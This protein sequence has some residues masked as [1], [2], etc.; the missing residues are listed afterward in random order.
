ME[1]PYATA[2]LMATQF[3]AK[4]F[5]NGLGL[6]RKHDLPIPVFSDSNLVLVICG[7]GKTNAAMGTTYCCITFKPTRILN[8]GAAGAVDQTSKLGDV[9]QIEKIF[10]PDRPS[11]NTRG[12][13][14]HTPETI[15]GFKTTTLATQDRPILDPEDR[16]NI[17]R[18]AHLVDMEA[19][20]VVQV[21]RQ[22]GITCLV[23]KFVSDTPDHTEALDIIS[24]IKKAGTGFFNYFHRN[25]LPRLKR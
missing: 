24:N 6:R 4:P 11:F 9:F 1:K 16:M 20:A 19:A 13:V 25:I 5:I 17:S 14:I 3:E 21:C 10:E 8:L 2:L 15:E 12:P 18:T 7:I 22:F 23:F